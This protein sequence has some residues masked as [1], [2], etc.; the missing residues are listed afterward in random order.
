MHFLK[1]ILPLINILYKRKPFVSTNIND[2]DV[3]KGLIRMS[4]TF[5]QSLSQSLS[6]SL[7][8]IVISND[9]LSEIVIDNC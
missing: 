8:Y 2:I 6:Q 4:H 3:E 7:M 5:T 9:E 1:N